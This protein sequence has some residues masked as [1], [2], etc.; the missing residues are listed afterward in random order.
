MSATVSIESRDYWFKI[1]EMLQ[2]NWALIEMEDDGITMY[3]VSDAS[4]VFD[5]ISLDLSD[6][7]KT[8]LSENGFRRFVDDPKASSSLNP[9]NPPF[10]FHS[11]SNGPIYSSG[12]F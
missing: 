5:Q 12:C 6:E 2:Q 1:I 11:H 10:I 7:A 3:F 9:P 4:G 8:A